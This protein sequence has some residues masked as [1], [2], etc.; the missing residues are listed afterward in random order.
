MAWRY[1]CPFIIYAQSIGPLYYIFTKKL[2]RFTFNRASVILA[3]EEISAN[4]MKNTINILP[5]KIIV[6][7]DSVFVLNRPHK[8]EIE[9]VSLSYSFPYKKFIVFVIRALKTSRDEMKVFRLFKEL[10]NFLYDKEIIEKCVIITQC[11][12]FP[13][14]K[15]FESDEEISRSL[16]E[17]LTR[18]KECPVELISKAFSHD[19]LLA[20]YAAARYVIS[21]RLHAALFSLISGT[22]VLAISVSG[23]KTE[24]IMQS[25]GLAKNVYKEGEVRLN[26]QEIINRLLE[27]EKNYD[28]N[29]QE[30]LEH[31]KLARKK[32]H[33]T[34]NIVRSFMI[35]PRND[36]KT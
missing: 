21:L 6:V 3:R 2:I 11:H 13:D 4:Y 1:R 36:L 7:P 20:I 15:G 10:A 26:K 8:K 5:Q 24:G 32:A 17:Y 29:V 23:F 14:Y 18:K 12:H 31:I 19:E 34:P 30:I 9:K 27:Y 16:F 28:G 22:P 35:W 25:L 33:E